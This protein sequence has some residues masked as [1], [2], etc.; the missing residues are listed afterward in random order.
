MRLDYLKRAKFDVLALVTVFALIF[1]TPSSILPIEGKAG[2]LSLFVTKFVL[3]SAG[4][5]HAHITRKILFPYIDFGEINERSWI[6]H[7]MIVALYVT[8]ILAW[9]RGG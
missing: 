2:L 7:A 6:R 1:V 4:I 9:A 3:V 5:L 8:I